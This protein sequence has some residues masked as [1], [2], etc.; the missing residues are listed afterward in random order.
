MSCIRE[1]YTKADKIT[2]F[3]RVYHTAPEDSEREK[4]VL[5]HGLGMSGKYMQPLAEA[6]CARYTVYVPDLPGFGKSSKP[7]HVLTIQELADA[8]YIWCRVYPVKQAWY[9]GN[10]VGCQ[11]IVDFAVHYSHCLKGVVLQGPVI[12]PCRRSETIQL[13]LFGKLALYEPAAVIM[14]L[15]KDYMKSGIKRVFKTFRYSLQYKIE[16]YLPLMNIP[17]VVVWGE[18][19]ELI[20]QQWV[21]M[22]VALLPDGRLVKIPNEAHA[23]NFTAPRLL[24]DITA[25]FIDNK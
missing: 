14:I 10:S 5:V 16:D 17:A 7:P 24:A 23:V 25:D 20:S 9:L 12:D 8:L 18:N 21:E 6:L 13:L 2:F 22:A 19:D 1:T 4:I 11:I 15:L 3:T